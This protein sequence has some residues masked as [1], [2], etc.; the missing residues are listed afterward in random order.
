MIKPQLLKMLFLNSALLGATSLLTSSGAFAANK[1]CSSAPL[2]HQ[3]FYRALGIDAQQSLEQGKELRHYFFDDRLAQMVE[4]HT[5]ENALKIATQ[6]NLQTLNEA[7]LRL[8]AAPKAPIS[9][10]PTGEALA[11]HPITI[12][13]VP[14]I[15]GEFIK[16]RP[17]EEILQR[18][19][20]AKKEF[21]EKIASVRNRNTSVGG[22]LGYDHTLELRTLHDAARPLEELIHISALKDSQGRETIK[23]VFLYPPFASLET[24][25]DLKKQSALFNRRLE[26]YFEI[27]KDENLVL[28]GYSRGTTY[29]LEMATQAK[30]KNL[31]YFKNL[32]G[33]ISY[34][35][36]LFGSSLADETLINN[37]QSQAIWRALLELRQSLV[38]VD[39]KNSLKKAYAH[40]A[41]AFAS[42]FK[43]LLVS[44]PLQAPD[45]SVLLDSVENADMKALVSIVSQIW[46]KLQLDHPQAF[47]DHVANFNRFIDEAALG[48][49]Q[50]RTPERTEWW[51]SNTLPAEIKYYA[52]SAAMS[53][54]KKSAF[55][56]ELFETP[57]G[58]ANTLD[59]KSLLGNHS[60][61]QT[62][63][64]LSLNDSQ[65][66][67]PQSVFLPQVIESLNAANNQ[68]IFDNLGVLGTHHWG[69]AL[70]TVNEMKDGRINPFPREAVLKA[71]AATVADD[72]SEANP[73]CAR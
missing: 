37:T 26:K 67:V 59:D 51:K 32:R 19:S 50:L 42:F 72:L 49:A 56:K 61:Y 25:G 58:Y 44:A 66:S 22:T 62:M 69:V 33:V 60:K 27:T 14:G 57:V 73:F 71:L 65:V 46:R 29:A 54:P 23:L 16:T 15:F 24:L 17:F 13:V 2:F 4:A 31:A 9:S 1:S 68:L 39:N 5:L 40:N 47:N 55:E 45:L 64:G 11:S 34:A 41:M 6:S 53:N 3:H 18:D 70:Q 38:S 28:L 30:Q 8:L 10:N 12:V 20:Q 35:G 43:S 52:I 63:T 48:I 36:V 21:L 7:T